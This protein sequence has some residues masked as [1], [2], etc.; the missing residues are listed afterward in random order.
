ML[1]EKYMHL[2]HIT[3]WGNKCFNSEWP[4]FSWNNN[5]FLSL[6]RYYTQRH[7]DSKG[8]VSLAREKLSILYEP[9]IGLVDYR[10]KFTPINLPPNTYDLYVRATQNFVRIVGMCHQS[11]RSH[12]TLLD[13]S[14]II[15]KCPHYKL[16]NMSI[17]A[18]KIQVLL[19]NSLL[20]LLV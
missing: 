14:Y 4:T 7:M 1:D 17:L 3:V 10:I 11:C 9:Y 13:V 15:S 8:L 12:S 6:G 16:I 20:A 2:Q 5:F 18:T 19:K